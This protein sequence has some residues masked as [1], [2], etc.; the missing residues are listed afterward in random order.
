MTAVIDSYTYELTGGAQF[1][2]I[3]DSTGNDEGNGV[4]CDSSGNIYL[5]GYY[6]AT[7]TIKDQSGTSLG[8]LPATS[9]TGSVAFV[10]K[11]NSSG[12]YQ[13]SRLVDATSATDQGLG[14]ACDS[15]DNMYIA[16]Y[17]SGTPTIKDQSGTSLGTLPASSGSAAFV[18]K[19]NSS[20]TYQYSR[21]VDAPSM[22]DQGNGVVCD[23]SGNMYIAGSYA[24][25]PTI[26]DQAGTSLGTLPASTS[27]LA[28]FVSKF[29]SSGAYQYSRIVDGGGNA[30]VA[31]GVTCDSTSN[32]YIAG[33]YNGSGTQT[34]KDQAGT[35][36]GTLPATS[37]TGS[38]AFVSKFN[39]S[40]T[41][42]YSR[43]VDATNTAE[44]GF[45]VACDSSDNMY[46]AGYYQ[47]T[48]T[49]KDQSGTS[50]GT[51]PTASSS[52]AFVCKFNS[53][54]IYQ[55]SRIVDATSVSEQGNGVACDSAGN[56]YIAGYYQGTP[57]IK[58]QAGTSLGTLPTS[59][60]GFAAFVS[61]FDSS[62]TY[63]FSR[64]V[65]STGNDE[66]NEVA[67]DSSD[68]MYIVGYYTGTP[69]IKD[70]AGTS[71]GT[72]PASSGGTTAYLIK[73]D[74]DGNYAP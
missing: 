61:K 66:G 2:R 58:D 24:G 31:W 49:I 52:A 69:T 19:F 14:V 30:E 40:G 56:M 5:V 9:G 65:D 28:A 8:T 33:Y 23:S 36:L 67:C 74:Q 42:Q 22:T 44:Q 12:T 59:S 20:G 13:Y 38:V 57:T 27:G 48:P 32:L 35:S 11:F 17:Y 51:L 25:T 53:S 55:Y 18:S 47:G 73:F 10:S 70:Q 54:G 64:V 4:A 26:K 50:L 60:G 62:G 39:S 41:Y 72:L 16:G 46:I 29:D 63:Q 1:S 6:S 71:L 43:I 15:S 34:I 7:P 21:I 45:G 68:N 3:V 37:G